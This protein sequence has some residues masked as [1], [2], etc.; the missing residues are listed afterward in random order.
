LGGI[1]AQCN[2]RGK[3]CKGL[4][5]DLPGL[6]G[7]SSAARAL[8][9]GKLSHDDWK[10]YTGRLTM[11]HY[12]WLHLASVAW[13]VFI[14]YWIV[15]A[16]KLKSIKQ[17]EPR[18]ERLI[19]LVLMVA[20]YFLMFNDQFSR[21]WLATRFVSAAPTIGEIGVALT[22]AGIAFAIWA[23]WHLGENWSATVTLKEGHELISSGPYRYIR[24]P[25]YT[26]ML[27][28]FVGTALALGE[29]RALISVCIVLFAFYIKA[30]K[31]E[32]FLTQEFGEKFRE[33][34]RRTGMFLPRLT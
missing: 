15:S 3:E 22:V 30:K 21:G 7:E 34:S 26:G 5:Q 33:H 12:H 9:L 20:A 27:L 28:A 31:E 32:R 10:S 4:A 24:H 8:T 16:Q 17:R 13:I 11:D 2:P 14:A 1:A 6:A 29:Y 19:Q 23:R 18:G 25:I